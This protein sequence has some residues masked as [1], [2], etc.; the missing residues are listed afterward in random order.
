M[1]R[2]SYASVYSLIPV[3]PAFRCRLLNV[4]NFMQERVGNIFL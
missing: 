1:K 2:T 3:Y 4:M